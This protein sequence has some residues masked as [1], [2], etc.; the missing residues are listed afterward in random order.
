MS[1]SSWSSIVLYSRV[2]RS[3]QGIDGHSSLFL[4]LSPSSSFHLFTDS[5][6]LPRLQPL[7]PFHNPSLPS[8]SFRRA[9][10][11]AHSSL[12][13]KFPKQCD[14]D[15]RWSYKSPPWWQLAFLSECLCSW[16][17]KGLSHNT[18]ELHA[19]AAKSSAYIRYCIQPSYFSTLS[20]TT[21]HVKRYLKYLSYK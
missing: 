20:M 3:G 15:Q 16:C 5:R 7:L 2:I 12:N 10:A 11:H 14:F 1:Q 8:P 13:Q 18:V 4:S 21:A 9:R 17:L 6:R 19:H